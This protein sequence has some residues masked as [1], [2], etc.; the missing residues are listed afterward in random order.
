M[1]GLLRVIGSAVL[2]LCRYRC[3]EALAALDSLPARQADTGWVHH[4]RGRAF[5]EMADYR[6]ARRCFEAMR[7]AEPHRM[8]GL[9]LF[10][11]TLWH[12]KDAVALAHLAQVAMATDRGAPETWCVTGNSFSLQKE[13]ETAQESLARA[14]QLDPNFTYAYTL[15]GHEHGTCL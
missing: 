10:S 6:R 12:L 14:V 1:L 4:R 9:E 3:K 8:E 2:H 7:A 11:T 13:H 5:F 15:C